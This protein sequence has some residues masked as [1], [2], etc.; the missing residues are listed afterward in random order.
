M[1][2][3][4]VHWACN[5]SR[6]GRIAD[7]DNHGGVKSL[8][9][10]G[11]KRFPQTYFGP[12]VHPC[13]GTKYWKTKEGANKDHT[14][15]TLKDRPVVSEDMRYLMQ[16]W[17]AAL[18]HNR[19]ELAPVCCICGVR[20]EYCDSNGSNGGLGKCRTYPFCMLA[21]HGRCAEALAAR[22][23]DS[24]TNEFTAFAISH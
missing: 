6:Q 2:V 1:S 24:E 18:N 14:A 22:I 16:M 9:Y 20:D 10:V 4:C 17:E 5:R 7:L 12:I 11:G 8:V 13:V 3:E 15:D 23:K 21:A 19:G